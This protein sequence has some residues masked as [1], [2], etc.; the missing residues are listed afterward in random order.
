MAF[1]IPDHLPRRSN[2][3]DVSSEILTK[4]DQATNKSLTA[5]LAGSWL[6][7]LDQNILSTK[8]RG[9]H[10]TRDQY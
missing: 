5:S 8:V 2:P 10:E 1:A 3:H 6:A 7:E 4:I 9:C